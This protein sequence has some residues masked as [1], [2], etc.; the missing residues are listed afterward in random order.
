MQSLEGYRLLDFGTA[1]AGPQV[2]QLLAD[3]AWKS[4]RLK[5]NKAGRRQ[6]GHPMTGIGTGSVNES[7]WL[8][9]QPVFH[10]MNRNKLSFTINLKHPRATEVLND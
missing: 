6:A 9:M 2:A 1:Q 3:M 5:Q 8:D 4:S 10:I 7:K